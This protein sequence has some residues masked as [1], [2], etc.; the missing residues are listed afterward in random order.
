MGTNQEKIEAEASLFSYISQ[1]HCSESALL[2]LRMLFQQIKSGFWSQCKPGKQFQSIPCVESLEINRNNLPEHLYH[3]QRQPAKIDILNYSQLGKTFCL[4]EIKSF[5]D[6]TFQSPGR[7]HSCAHRI[8]Y[9][10]LH[11][12]K[13]TKSAIKD[14][15]VVCSFLSQSLGYIDAFVN[16]KNIFTSFENL[17]YISSIVD[18]NSR[19]VNFYEENYGKNIIENTKIISS[20]EIMEQISYEKIARNNIIKFKINIDQVNNLCLFLCRKFSEK[21]FL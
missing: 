6:K 14:L 20:I 17:I 9:D 2:H 15:N 5:K 1:K 11:G 8:S 16:K 10:L 13:Q 7:I 12:N 19:D 3:P 4:S 18:D 21:Y